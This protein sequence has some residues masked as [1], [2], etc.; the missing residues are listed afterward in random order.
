M[1]KLNPYT[2][3]VFIAGRTILYTLVHHKWCLCLFW[4]IWVPAGNERRTIYPQQGGGVSISVSWANPV[5]H[6][7]RHGT[8]THGNV[9]HSFHLHTTAVTT[10]WRGHAMITELLHY[11]FTTDSFGPP[12][13]R[14]ARLMRLN[15]CGMK[16]ERYNVEKYR[17]MIK[18]TASWEVIGPHTPSHA[19]STKSLS[20]DRDAS[21]I[22]GM[23]EKQ[24]VDVD[25]QE[26]IKNQASA[27]LDTSFW[28]CSSW[29]STY[30]L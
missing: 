19:M 9:I 7:K 17:S 25:V 23:A 2:L 26:H 5:L 28:W 4:P 22:S 15:C 16:A 27:D 1:K 13:T 6:T 12:E 3:F 21:W 24:I 11:L 30:Q 29:S 18:S 8:T 10:N 20:P 14:G